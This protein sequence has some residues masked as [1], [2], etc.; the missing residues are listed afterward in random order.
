MDTLAYFIIGQQTETASDINDT[1]NLAKRL[2]PDYVHFTVF[3]PYPGTQIYKEGLKRGIIKK[4]VWKEFAENPYEGFELPVWE[5]NF[6]R[7]ELMRIIV[8]CYKSF[9]LRPGYILKRLST[10]RGIGEM[11]RKLRAGW[12]VVKMKPDERL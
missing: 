4:D 5:E 12:G 3:S 11:S 1:I 8:R 10:I 9:Y 6:K 7:E 2:A